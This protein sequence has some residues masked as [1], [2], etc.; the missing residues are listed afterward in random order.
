M[1]NTNLID[2]LT[3]LLAAE[4]AVGEWDMPPSMALLTEGKSGP[5][6]AVPVE[7]IPAMW[8][9]GRVPDVLGFVAHILT[10]RDAPSLPA[11]IPEGQ[12]VVGIALFTE[13]WALV[14]DGATEE[15]REEAEAF[16]ANHS[17][18][19]H[20]LGAESKTLVA[21]AVD[22]GRYAIC[23][24]RGNDIPIW[25]EAGDDAV[26]GGAVPHA[27]QAVLDAALRN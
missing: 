21:I 10:T 13:S 19:D 4:V 20:P 6:S 23:Q 25:M 15:E 27:L 9:M 14:L 11:E 16:C 8:E 18:A 7:F 2:D 24:T 22:G 3:V 12:E 5:V 1:R 26:V 17:V